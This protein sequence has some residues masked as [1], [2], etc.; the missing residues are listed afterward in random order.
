MP[1]KKDFAL[2]DGGVR[3]DTERYKKPSDYLKKI[4]NGSLG[5]RG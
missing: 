1:L 5:L 3:I 4:V 2:R